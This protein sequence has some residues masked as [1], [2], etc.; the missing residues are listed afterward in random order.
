[1]AAGVAD[2]VWEVDEI[3]ALLVTLEDE[4]EAALGPRRTRGRL[5]SK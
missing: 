3:V 1:M 4:R 5:E 2:H